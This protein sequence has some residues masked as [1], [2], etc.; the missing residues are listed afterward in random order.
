MQDVSHLKRFF[1]STKSVINTNYDEKSTFYL[2]P[3]STIDDYI[4]P[5]FVVYIIEMNDGSI[6]YLYAQFLGYPK[7]QFLDNKYFSECTH[8]L[9]SDEIPFPEEQGV[10][11][12]NRFK[13]FKN[14]NDKIHW[15]YEL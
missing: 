12:I 6:E 7:S 8:L 1:G 13:T 10:S 4:K 15:K 14:L 9:V 2:V 5:I 3:K 11:W